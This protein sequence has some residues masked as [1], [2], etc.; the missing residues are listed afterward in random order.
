[1][2]NPKTAAR[3]DQFDLPLPPRYG[4]LKN[5]SSRERVKPRFFVTFNIILTY[6]FPENFIEFTQVVRKIRRS[7]LSILAFFM[8][9]Y[10]ETNDVSL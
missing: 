6:I 4:F 10:K 9:F 2:L 1:M 3:E 7:S 5:V 8:N